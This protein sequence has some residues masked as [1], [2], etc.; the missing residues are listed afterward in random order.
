MEKRENDLFQFS[1]ITIHA[2]PQLRNNGAA[3]WG[4]LTFDTPVPHRCP[5]IAGND[6]SADFQ[7]A[8]S[9]IARFPL[10]GK[11]RESEPHGPVILRT[12]A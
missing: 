3:P 1:P 8:T 4:A 6:D 7:L 2:T 9:R 11:G 5:A 10:S 12:S